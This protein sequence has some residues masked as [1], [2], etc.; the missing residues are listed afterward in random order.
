MQSLL[1]F[2]VEQALILYSEI[3]YVGRR[4]HCESYYKSWQS[5]TLKAGGEEDFSTRSFNSERCSYFYMSSEDNSLICLFAPLLA[6]ALEGFELT[7]GHAPRGFATSVY[8]QGRNNNYQR[9][10]DKYRKPHGGAT[11]GNL[12]RRDEAQHKGE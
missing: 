2:Y 8:Y 3:I 7:I 6:F 11:N 5:S 4:H 9:S 12:R 1:N 10:D